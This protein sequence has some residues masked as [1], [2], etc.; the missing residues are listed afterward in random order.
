MK[1]LFFILCFFSLTL[2]VQAQQDVINLPAPKKTGG[3]PLMEALS[4]RK[5]IRA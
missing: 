5:S 4:E 1:Q 2:C 3:K